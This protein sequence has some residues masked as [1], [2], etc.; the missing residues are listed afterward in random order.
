MMGG[1]AA[2]GASGRSGSAAGGGSGLVGSEGSLRPTLDT[3]AWG[4][5]AI[6]AT[7]YGHCTDGQ[8]RGGRGGVLAGGGEGGEGGGQWGRGVAAGKRMTAQEPADQRRVGC[9]A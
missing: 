7:P 2:L 6:G 5:L 9:A 1:E 3:R 4:S 8:V